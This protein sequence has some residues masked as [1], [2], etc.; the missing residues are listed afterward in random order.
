MPSSLLACFRVNVIYTTQALEEGERAFL[1]GRGWDWVWIGMCCAKTRRGGRRPL[2]VVCA[3]SFLAEHME[4]SQVSNQLTSGQKTRRIQCSLVDWTHYEF[5][6]LAVLRACFYY[7]LALVALGM[8]C[9]KY[10]LLPQVCP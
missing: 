7:T 3:P 5:K 2:C 6:V 8:Y 1:R 9:A 4:L 10:V